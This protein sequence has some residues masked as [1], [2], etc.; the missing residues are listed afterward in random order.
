MN[1]AK[2]SQA[3]PSKKLKNQTNNT[4]KNTSII[5][6]HLK[7]LKKHQNNFSSSSPR[8][9]HCV[10]VTPLYVN[11]KRHLLPNTAD[12]SSSIMAPSGISI[13]VLHAQTSIYNCVNTPRC[14]P[15]KRRG[16]KTSEGVKTL[17]L[18]NINP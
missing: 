18:Q 15:L 17:D 10:C 5:Q 1:I 12:P 14:F 2:P 6:I 7:C 9:V 3:K 4:T 11:G 16:Q 8:L 13:K